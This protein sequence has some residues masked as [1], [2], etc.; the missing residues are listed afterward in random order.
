MR[1]TISNVERVYREK[2]E[3]EAEEAL[4]KQYEALGDF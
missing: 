4:R 1:A 2:A 3:H